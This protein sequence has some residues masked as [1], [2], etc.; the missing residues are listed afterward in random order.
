MKP[1]SIIHLFLTYIIG[2][3]IISVLIGIIGI[4]ISFI[5][6]SL[7]KG[8][9]LHDNMKLT[10]AIAM[11]AQFLSTAFGIIYIFEASFS[12]SIKIYN[13]ICTSQW[14]KTL[15]KLGFSET[16]K[17]IE[18]SQNKYFTFNGLYKN[19]PFEIGS[20]DYRHQ[21]IEIAIPLSLNTKGD[22]NFDKFCEDL[23]N[24][25]KE[26][27]AYLIESK[28]YKRLY[29]ANGIED[30]EIWE[31]MNKLIEIANNESYNEQKLV[32]YIVSK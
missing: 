26:I 15:L 3:F 1:I 24:S 8:N 21:F 30:T 16:I 27:D 19:M 5:A 11:I 7:I 23:S 32:S 25:Y 28:L 20:K 22:E 2:G 14:R 13:Q 10:F 6:S 9:G 12:K 17:D 31:A 4:I 18:N 29:T